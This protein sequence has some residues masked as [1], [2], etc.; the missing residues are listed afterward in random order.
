MDVVDRREVKRASKGKGKENVRNDFLWGLEQE[1]IFYFDP[2]E[3]NAAKSSLFI[4]CFKSFHIFSL[5]PKHYLHIQGKIRN[6]VRIWR[7]NPDCM[8]HGSH[9][10]QALNLHRY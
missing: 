6:H 8:D 5:Y 3:G 9:Q 10:T 4:E 1:A 7:F 2:A